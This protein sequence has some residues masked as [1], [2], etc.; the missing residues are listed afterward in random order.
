MQIF[1]NLKDIQYKKDTIVTLGTFDGVHLGHKEII[2]TVVRKSS[3][4]ASRSFLITFDPHPRKVLS[5]DNGIKLLTT[6]DEKLEIIKSF[7]ME[8]L[9]LVNFTR[10][11][12]QQSPE[13]F[14]RKYIVDGIGMKEIVIGYDH[15]FGKGR[16]GNVETLLELG[17]EIGFT[18]TTVPELKI[19]NETVSST[20]IRNAILNG[21]CIKAAK[22]LGRYYSFSGLVVHGDDR[23]KEL[24]FPTANLSVIDEDKLLPAIGIYAVKCIIDK[25]KYYGLLSIGTRPTFY[26]SG[27]IIPE[28]YL[29]DFNQNIYGKTVT[30]NLVEKI[31]DE[32]K[33]SSAEEL[34]DQMN[35]DKKSGQE[36]LAKLI[37]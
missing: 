36:I 10:E 17:K 14:I 20:K 34:I 37:N 6:L 31:R 35:R 27:E 1:R 29:F 16:G 30:V 2:E 8:N 25:Q 3:K 19:G 28:I 11:F 22:M 21:D 26:Q 33:F 7:K 15:H 23:G 9:F 13:E 18:V 4:S 12:S 24:G 32:K 5:Q